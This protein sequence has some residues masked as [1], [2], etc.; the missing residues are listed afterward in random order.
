M[1]VSSIIR[2]S[3]LNTN[4]SIWQMSNDQMLEYLNIV[5]KDVFSRLV[6]N[7]K[8]YTRQRY[9]TDLVDWQNEYILPRPDDAITGLK[10]ILD[11]YTDYGKWLKKTRIYD[12]ETGEETDEYN[13]Y[14]IQRDW[15]VF[16]YPTP[17]TGTLVLEWKYI[18]LDLALSDVDSAIKLP[19]EYH[20]VLIDWLNMWV[21]G[22]KQL[23]D[24]QAIM[25]ANY[26]EWVQRIKEEWAMDVESYYE[27][28]NINFC[29]LE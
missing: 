17:W 23:F 29:W 2:I 15:S 13:P 10:L 28:D 27:E 25:K 14:I 6:I 7:S 21:F 9:T 12:T 20:D 18:P 16:L 11:V 8:K 19:T 4:T 24:K 3:R 26:N 5:Y 1:D 22:E